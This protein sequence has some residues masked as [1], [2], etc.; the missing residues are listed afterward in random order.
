MDTARPLAKIREF[1]RR[2]RRMPS[3]RELA[4]L[5]GYRSTNA[6]AKLVRTMRE[7]GLLERDPTGRIRMRH[8]YGEAR[9]LGAVEAGWP[10]PAEEELVDTM[11]L[12]EWLIGNKEATFMLKVQGISMTGAGIMP[13]D[14]VLVE[15]GAPARD[16]DIVVAEV[17]KAWTIKY[18]RKRDGQTILEPAN[19][20]YRTIVPSEELNIAAVVK[21]VIRKY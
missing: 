3:Y 17:D 5:V 16:G 14:M 13:G 18:L 1:F 11:S 6:V 2:T 8:P 12:D 21:A 19:P 15:R 4:A 10:S 9:V 20:K 7:A